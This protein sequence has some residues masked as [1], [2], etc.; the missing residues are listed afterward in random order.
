MHPVIRAALDR[1]LKVDV[2]H[3]S[4]FSYRLAKKAIAAGIIPTTLGADIHGYNTNVRR[5]RRARRTTT[6]TRRPSFRRSGEVQPASR[7]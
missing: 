7:R 4:H 2:G 3:G 6:R 5:T 1:G